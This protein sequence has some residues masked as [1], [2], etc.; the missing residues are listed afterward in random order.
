MQEVLQ[1]KQKELAATVAQVR[2]RVAVLQDALGKARL[3][4]VQLEAK[5]QFC[6]QLLSDSR[7]ES[8]ATVTDP[9]P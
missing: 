8:P 9:Q 1:Q 4:Q 5:L 6:T 2:N 3:E 7:T